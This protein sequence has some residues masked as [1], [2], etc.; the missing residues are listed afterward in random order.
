MLRAMS[1]L[2]IMLTATPVLA[3]EGGGTNPFAGDFGNALWTLVVFLLVVFVLGKFA[4]GPILKGLQD[5]ENFIA[6]SLSSAKKDREEAQ[7]VMADYQAQIAK[8]KDEAT[9][10][11]EEGRRDAEVLR[12]KIEDAAKEEAKNVSERARREIELATDNAVKQ[13]YDVSGQLATEIASRIIRKEL[14]A[15][16]HERLINDSIDELSSTIEKN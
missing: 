8:A 7:R 5:R 14:D 6:E 11:V 3:A 10:I 15:T 4:W 16:E 12:R 9:A 1:I 2:G 13:L